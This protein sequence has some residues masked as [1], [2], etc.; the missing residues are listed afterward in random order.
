MSAPNLPDGFTCEQAFARLYEYLDRALERDELRQVEEHLA[1]CEGCTHH[2][3]F[4]E[5]LLDQI[6]EKC[7]T[8][9]APESLRR[10]IDKL[11]D[12]L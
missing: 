8:G 3:L 10:R 6:R 1:I 9:R 12:T 4:E 11:L 2:F 5:K 7:Q